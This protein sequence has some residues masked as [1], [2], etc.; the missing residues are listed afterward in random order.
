M[1]MQ[2]M[3]KRNYGNEPGGN[4][5][6]A[7]LLAAIQRGFGLSEGELADL[8]GVSRQAVQQ[9]RLRGVPNTRIA[10]VDR[11]AEL[12][13]VLKKRLIPRRLPQIVRTPAK[14]LQGHTLL[15]TLSLYGVDR[16]YRYLEELYTYTTT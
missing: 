16:V 5:A 7:S 2:C 8:F 10:D 3:E 1:Y 14:G 4:V 15:Q 12:A 6:A 9:W 11:I 13:A